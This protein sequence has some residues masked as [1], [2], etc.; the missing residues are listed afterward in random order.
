MSKVLGPIHHWL[1]GK[2]GRQEELTAALAELAMTEGWLRD[3]APYVRHLPA[4]ESVIDEGNIHGWLQAQITDAEERYAGLVLRLTAQE[5]RLEA[6]CRAARDFGQT[7][8]LP[9][10]AAPTEAYRAFEDFFVNGMPC[11]RVNAVTE[12]TYDRLS[13]EQ[14]REL[15]AP[16]WEARGGDAALYYRLRRS[17]M[18]GM[19]TGTSLRLETPDKDHYSLVR[20]S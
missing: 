18:E 9:A 3:A 13:W 6:L 8:A 2:I 17:V 7:Q 10:N 5:G 20:L 16:I 1:Y 14:T 11:D 4:L 15:H 19:L 12:D